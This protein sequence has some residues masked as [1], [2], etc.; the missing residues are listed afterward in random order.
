MHIRDALSKVKKLD[1]TISVY[2]NK[3]KALSDTLSS[4]GQPLRPEEF[5]AYLLK[6][7]DQD[8]NSLEIGRAHV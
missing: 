6:G 8:Y 3:V 5:S 7:L 1:T 4:I 2:F